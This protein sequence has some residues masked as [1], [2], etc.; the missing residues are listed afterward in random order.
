MTCKYCNS[1]NV[2]NSKFCSNCGHKLEEDIQKIEDKQE[3]ISEDMAVQKT[4]QP[5]QQTVVAQQTTN[6]QPQS[7]VNEQS[8][9]IQTNQAY[10]KF[11]VA[12]FV[13]SLIGIFVGAIICGI[14]G[15]T[16][17]SIALKDSDKNPELKGRGM[18]IAALIISIIDIMAFFIVL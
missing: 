1:E 17:A 11:S 5:V 13:I 6:V 14:I 3:S 15:C 2:E 18:A 9:Q 12:A 4:E 16:F 10:C 7:F 8:S